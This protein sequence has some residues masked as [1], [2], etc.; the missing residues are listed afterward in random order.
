M[1]LSRKKKFFEIGPQVFILQPKIRHGVRIGPP[2][3]K[4]NFLDLY[5]RDG[6]VNH[7]PLHSNKFAYAKGKSTE[8][9]LQLSVPR[10][11]QACNDKEI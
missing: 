7:S 3:P 11:E 9:A 1:R 10:A 2:Y 8:N 5:V 6:F 4:L